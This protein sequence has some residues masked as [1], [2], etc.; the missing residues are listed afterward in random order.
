MQPA[1]SEKESDHY[2]AQFVLCLLLVLCIALGMGIYISKLNAWIDKKKAYSAT[3]SFECGDGQ[4]AFIIDSS[5]KR[6][7]C[8]FVE[9]A[10]NAEAK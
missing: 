8:Y 4:G 2:T 3:H 10:E 9:E 1:R 6:N 5:G 7:N